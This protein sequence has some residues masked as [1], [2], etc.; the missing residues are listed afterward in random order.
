MKR[1]LG[2]TA[3]VVHRDAGPS[4][5]AAMAAIAWDFE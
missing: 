1:F 3:V 4:R 5:P 2:L